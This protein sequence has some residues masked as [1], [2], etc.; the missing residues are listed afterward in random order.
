MLHILSISFISG[1]NSVFPI[2][3]V[4]RLFISRFAAMVCDGSKEIVGRII[5]GKKRI[6][7]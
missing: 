1:K 5:N 2:I 4:R 7:F 6:C 3:P